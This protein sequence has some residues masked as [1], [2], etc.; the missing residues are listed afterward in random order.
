[1]NR[2]TGLRIKRALDVVASAILLVVLAPVM[3]VVAG[4]VWFNF[5]RPI[6]YRNPRIAQHAGTFEALKFRSMRDLFDANGKPLPDVERMTR[7]SK[8]IRTS[9]LDELPQLWNV[10]KGEMSLI[11]PRPLITDYMPYLDA[12]EHRRLEMPPGITGLAQV[13][14]RN[15]LDWDSRL[16]M[17][18]WY[19]ENWSLWL[20]IKVALMTIPVWLTGAGVNTPGHMSSLRLDDARRARI[21]P[22]VSREAVLQ[23]G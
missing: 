17:D 3:F 4:L 5:G 20:D 10:L 23:D 2:S 11:G 15:S 9:S 14:G 19:V 16:E 8:I 22:A 18:V 6:I 12:L 13:N 21:Q 7:F 1:M